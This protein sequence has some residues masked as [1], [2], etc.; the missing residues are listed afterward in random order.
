MGL[1]SEGLLVDVFIACGLSTWMGLWSGR[2]VLAS[3]FSFLSSSLLHPL[4]LDPSVGSSQL[5]KQ[6][7]LLPSAMNH[8][9]SGSCNTM[10][11]GGGGCIVRDDA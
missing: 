4:S 9:P 11:A 1:P 2:L 7:L 8:P 6:L 5:F 10:L 3:G